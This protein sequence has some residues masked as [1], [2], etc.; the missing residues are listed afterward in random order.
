MFLQLNET[1]TA[2]ST[3]YHRVG[4]SV[5]ANR[6]RV[7]GSR[8]PIGSSTRFEDNRTIDERMGKREEPV[9]PMI[10]SPA[11]ANNNDNAA[12][13]AAHAATPV[14]QG[15]SSSRRMWRRGLG[16]SSGSTTTSRLRRRRGTST[17]RFT[18]DS[19]KPGDN[20]AGVSGTYDIIKAAPAGTGHDFAETASGPVVRP[21]DVLRVKATR[22]GTDALDTAVDTARWYHMAVVYERKLA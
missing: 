5:L 21:G 1:G 19:F 4:S 12:V 16:R 2:P 3:A 17:G 20:A 22:K 18:L 15:R 9:P 7:A 10:T 11:F 13:N 6:H 8:I 14:W